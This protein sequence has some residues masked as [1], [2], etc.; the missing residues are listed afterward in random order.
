MALRW[1]DGVEKT[2]EII[3]Y[4]QVQHVAIAWCQTGLVYILEPWNGVGAW[5]ST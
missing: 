5:A 2:W 3:S 1:A 4:A